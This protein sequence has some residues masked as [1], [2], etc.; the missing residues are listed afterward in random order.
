MN[1]KASVLHAAFPPD[2]RVLAVSDIHGNLPFLEGL[3]KAARY[4]PQDILVFVGDL[5][6]KGPDSLA[7]LRFVM[8][9]SQTNTVYALRGNCDNLVTELLRQEWEPAPR[10]FTQY[11]EVWQDRSL[12]VQMGRA[13][14]FAL[15]T[16]EDLP[17]LRRRVKSRLAPEY[18]FLT[19]MPDILITPEYLFV[20]GGVPQEDHLEDLT[21]HQCLKNDNF[22]PQGHVFRRWC[23]VGHW[24]VT[25]YDPRIPA[26]APLLSHAQHIASIDGGCVLKADGQLNALVL[27]SAPGGP[28]SWYSYDGLPAARALDPQEERADSVNIR[29]GRSKVEVLEHGPLLS[30]CRHL[31]TGRVLEILTEY[32]YQKDGDICCEDSTDYCPPV[33]PGDV[34]SIVRRLPDRTLVKRDGVTGWYFGR[35]GEETPP[36]T[37]FHEKTPEIS[38]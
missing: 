12:L 24:P 26:A 19:H 13:A 35:L 15:Q 14:D 23:V 36:K 21:A 5:V 28:F 16:P 31:E 2:R 1:R 30:R 9:L 34:L 6:E 8:E 37:F 11:L 38:A 33:E 32:L 3:L 10:F 18:R 27:P 17:E 25:L 22:L 29:W 20:H 4:T 7:V